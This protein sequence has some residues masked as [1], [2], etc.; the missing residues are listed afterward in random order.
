[1]ESPAKPKTRVAVFNDT[2]GSGHY[3]CV[4]V[5]HTLRRMLSSNGI[6]VVWTWPLG[7]DWRLHKDEMPRKGEI[8]AVIVNG[9]GTMHH[10]AKRPRVMA[11]AEAV[12]LA[13]DELGVPAFLLNATLY[14][15]SQSLY[16][17]IRRFD[18]VFVRDELSR[19]EL[20]SFGLTA[21][22]VPD[23]TFAFEHGEYA[24]ARNGVG[25]TDSV[26][27]D[28]TDVLYVRSRANGWDFRKM[29]APKPP[30]LRSVRRPHLFVKRLHS[31]LRDRGAYLSTPE[32]FLQWL[33]AREVLVTGRF[34]TVTM[35][36]VTQTPFVAVE[37]NTPKISSLL[38]SALGSTSRIIGPDTIH[39][40]DPAAFAKWNETE[41]A[42]LTRFC[43][44]AKAS[45]EEMFQTIASDIS[46]SG[47]PN[48]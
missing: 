29:S 43:N 41:L 21:V 14:E 36:L 42:S 12:N 15:N 20:E 39:S 40:L 28:I 26:H 30:P 48:E 17:L 5:M 33:T 32:N 35:S 44:G 1:M 46:K 45:I 19:D 47:A 16:D 34:H 31:W 13:H 9:E 2:S 18:R 24:Q 10:D 7:K 27:R 38:D 3:G 25:A 37:S 11:L 23:L 4:A 6:D 22:V 8:D